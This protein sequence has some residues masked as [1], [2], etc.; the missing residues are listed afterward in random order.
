MLVNVTAPEE[1]LGSVIGDLNSRRGMIKSQDPQPGGVSR[2]EAIVPL[3]KM[4]GYIS[5]LRTITSDV[6][7]SLWSFLVMS[8]ALST[9]KTK[10]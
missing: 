6:E 10:S 9:F 5:E 8:S 4:F 2:I 3:A 7:T 1:Q